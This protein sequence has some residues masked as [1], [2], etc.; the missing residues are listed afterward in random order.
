MDRFAQLAVAA[1]RQAE[2]DSGFEIETEAERVGAS[3][4]TGIGGL[5][6]FED[7]YD[8]LLERGPDRVNP[9]SI[10]PIIPNMGAAWVSIEL[11]TRG[12][13][14][15]AVHGLRRVAHGDRR[16]PRR[17][18]ARPRRR[19]ALRRHRGAAMTRVGI[20][21]FGAMRALS[22]R[23]DD[24]RARS[25]PFDAD[26]DG[27]VMG[28]AGAMLVLEEL[29]HAQGARREDLRRAARLRRLVRRPRTSPSPIRPAKP[30]ARDADGASAT[31]ASSPTRST[32]S[33]LTAPRRRSATRAR[34]A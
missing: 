18:P 6:A 1:A 8:Q 14:V 27:F 16:R 32:T 9:F 25:R 11:G 20:A 33:T 12:P 29:E 34:R 2:A 23:N 24:P 30:G 7:C 22:R 4:A 13:L 5:K 15:L 10:P 17:D 19:D 21:G 31:R 28:E 3:I 26:R